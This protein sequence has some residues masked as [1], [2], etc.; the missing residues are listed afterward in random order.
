ML[1]RSVAA[2]DA[3]AARAVQQSPHLAELVTAGTHPDARHADPETARWRLSLDLVGVL[4]ASAASQ[5]TLVVI[6]DLHEAD[7]S[8]LQLL[9]ELAPSLRSMAVVVLATARDSE[10]DWSSSAQVW[11]V[12]NRLGHPIRLGPFGKADIASLLAQALGMQAPAEAVRTIAARTQGNPLLVCEVVRSRPDLGD[13]DAVVPA[14]VRAIVAARLAGS[15][16]LTRTV[17]SAA[18]VLGTRF[19]LD[20]LAEVAEVPLAELGAVVGEA[21]AVGLFGNAEPGEG[22]FRH[23]LIR[24]AGYDALPVEQRMRW[25]ARAG[26]VLAVFA[27]RGRD[28]EPAQVADHLFRGGLECGHE[29]VEFAVQA[30]DQA[31]RRLAFEDAVRWYSRADAGLALVGAGD[32]QRARVKLALGEARHAAGDRAQARSDLLAAAERARRAGRP[33]LLAQAALGLSAGPVGFEVELLDQEQIVLLKEARAALPADADALAALVTARLSIALTLLATAQQRQDLAEEAVRAARRIGDD[34]AVAASLAA[35]CDALSGPDHCSQRRQYATEIVTLG[36]RL[37]DP[38]WELLGRRLRLVALLEAGAMAEADAEV[39]AYRTAAQSLGHPLYLWYVPLWRGMRALLEGR[40]DDCRAALD[41]TAALGARAASHN[42]D[43]LLVTQRWCLLAE[44]GDRESLTAMWAQF[45]AIDMAGI[46]PQI[47]RGL[48]LAQLGLLDDARAQ[49]DAT[50]PQLPSAPR[51]SEWLPLMAQVAELV[52]IIGAHPAAMWAYEALLPYAELFVVEGI[53][54]AVR[55]PVHYPLGLLAA[56]MGD[57]AAAAPHFAAASQAARAVG[58][59]RLA[60]RI[61]AV[62]GGRNA[63]TDNVFRRDGDYWTIRHRSAEFRLRDSKGLRDLRELLA[64]PGTSIAALDLATSPGERSRSRS[65]RD[66][67]HPPSDAGE[68]L[69]AAAR[70]AYRRRLQELDQEADDADAMN[71]AERSARLAA[72]RDTLLSALTTAYGLGGR[73]RRMGSPAERART[74][75]TTRIRDAIRRIRQA[76]PDLGEHLARSVRTGTFCVY[77]PVTPVHWSVSDST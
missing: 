46:W 48:L 27:Q 77:D 4:A 74:A 26:A 44:L 40:Y 38:A 58:A 17:V 29:A 41:E 2:A 11:G 32:E 10:R 52:G 30:A 69:D 62:A 12:L 66:E 20:V 33:D 21:H 31:L 56:A 8:S 13:L 39:L 72:E 71:D 47:A 45:G 57:R 63:L 53:G 59:P 24:D 37:H 36:Q 3:G 35:L 61:R 55:G 68:V 75:V 43:M 9:T 42:A 25:H 22:R 14:S 54:A 19:R 6:D 28:I 50:A 51:D 70:A 73:A 16:E 7:P 23:D 18:A 64:H 49:L 65:A 67:L 1:V 60:E 34:G 15:T 5:P 76:D